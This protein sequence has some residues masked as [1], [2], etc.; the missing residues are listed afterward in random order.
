MSQIVTLQFR[1]GTES[2]PTGWA[3]VN[4]TLSQGEPGLATGVT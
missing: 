3:A 2:G 1:R 4:T